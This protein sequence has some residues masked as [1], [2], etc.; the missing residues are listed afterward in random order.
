M[1]EH[2]ERL[3]YCFLVKKLYKSNHYQNP[4]YRILGANF[5]NGY[6]LV[7][8]EEYTSEKDTNNPD[9]YLLVENCKKPYKIQLQR[10]E[11]DSPYI[12]ID[13]NHF[14]KNV[15]EKVLHLL[16]KQGLC[17]EIDIALSNN[18]NPYLLH[19]LVVCLYSNILNLEVH[20][21]YKNKRD[22]HISCLT[23]VE[24]GYHKKLDKF[25]EP[26]FSEVT[27]KLYKEFEDLIFKKSRDTLASRLN[28]VFKILYKLSQGKSVKELTSKKI[29]KT[30]IYE[31]KKHYF[32]LK[33]FFDFLEN[34]NTE[35]R[36]PLDGI[37]S[38]QWYKLEIL[39]VFKRPDYSII[40]RLLKEI[41]NILKGK[42]KL[43]NDT[44]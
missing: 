32:Y 5:V 37:L 41:Q 18:T 22:N 23:P 3:Y 11:Q 17:T 16:A 36:E 10:T 6:F 33:E 26:K 19:R 21:N 28:I 20:H 38:K 24:S 12:K 29:K 42:Q 40:K 43:S 30:K 15:D 34:V 2:L 8:S 44:S 25:P 14:K 1:L 35:W 31:L 9:Y 27:N 39:G 13:K 7:V 4:N